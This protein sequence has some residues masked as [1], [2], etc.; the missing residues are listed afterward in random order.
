MPRLSPSQSP[1]WGDIG[2]GLSNDW[3]LAVSS[4][5]L[6]GPHRGSSSL[7]PRGGPCRLVCEGATAHPPPGYHMAP[8]TFVLNFHR[9]FWAPSVWRGLWGQDGGCVQP[10]LLPGLLSPS[11]GA[12]RPGESAWP[13]SAECCCGRCCI[14]ELRPP[15][16]PSR[17]LRY[18]SP[19]GT[20]GKR[21]SDTYQLLPLGSCS[22]AGPGW[23][24]SPALSH[25]CSRAWFQTVPRVGFA[26]FHG[27]VTTTA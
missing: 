11:A 22:A 16:Y 17:C 1:S 19:W 6:N 8:L 3:L 4:Q 23:V 24:D 13:R 26:L 10:W 12:D 20:A 9:D 25:S 21:E 7:A 15:L 2:R 27:L 18:V 14:C 5:G